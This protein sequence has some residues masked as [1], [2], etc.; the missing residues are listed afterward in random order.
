[1]THYI[2]IMPGA[3]P[4]FARGGDVGCLCLHGLGASPDE[5]RW[6]AE[7][8]AG[9]GHTV[10]APR[11]AGHGTT[12]HEMMRHVR[13]Q[14]WYTSALDA[15]HI[16]RAQC[17]RVF[18][19]GLSMGGLLATLLGTWQAVDGVAIMAAPFDLPEAKLLPYAGAIKHLWR[20][21]DYADQTDFPH[22]LRA[23]RRRRA[24]PSAERG[25]VRYSRMPTNGVH[26]LHKLMHV[27]RVALT[28]ITAPAL[29][30]YSEA[31]QTVPF[32]NFDYAMTHIGSPTVTAHTFKESG[33]ILTQ[34]T[35]HEAVFDCVTR[36]IA[37]IGEV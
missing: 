28:Q 31:D 16:L 32:H 24:E 2:D 10:Y 37:Q 8:L 19:A 26:Q 35:E 27:A 21:M 23:E 30:L 12:D 9:E 7:H 18:V 3:E 11:I 17:E 36:F 22:R 4:Y 25:R 13:W 20:T 34:D 5:V 33:H 29:L 15:Y 6:L 14:D 1:M